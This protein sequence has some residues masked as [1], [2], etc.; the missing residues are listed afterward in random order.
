MPSPLALSAPSPIRYTT[1][2]CAG[3]RRQDANLRE[4]PHGQDDRP[5][6]GVVGHDRQRE[7]QDPGEGGHPA[8]PV[9]SHLRGELED[10]RTLAEEDQAQEEEGQ[11]RGA[12]VL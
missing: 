11:A 3:W 6:G 5:R 8:G 2:P 10:G 7:G 12:P 1:N 9:A 4:D